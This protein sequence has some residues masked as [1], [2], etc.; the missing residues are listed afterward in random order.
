[1]YGI[2]THGAVELTCAVIGLG[3]GARMVG[4]ARR[5]KTHL[6]LYALGVSFIV[7]GALDLVH[8]AVSTLPQF[9]VGRRSPVAHIVPWTGPLG[10][11]FVI[12]G[13]AR[14]WLALRGV[15]YRGNLHTAGLV[16]IGVAGIVLAG[17]LLIALPSPYLAHWPY[18]PLDA[19]LT[20]PF[21]ALAVAYRGSPH[22]WPV[23]ALESLSALAVASSVATYDGGHALAHVAKVGAYGWLCRFW[24]L[25]RD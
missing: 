22:L 21:A 14:S 18:R 10:R 8:A 24:R 1:M 23:F 13:A 12:T 20:V 3:V 6:W 25:D 17:V 15:R 16:D 11:L 4:A 5:S 2:L 7:A 19:A 9:A